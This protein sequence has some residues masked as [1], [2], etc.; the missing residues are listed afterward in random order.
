MES[1]EV[2]RPLRLW[3]RVNASMVMCSKTW[4]LHRGSSFAPL[5]GCTPQFGSLDTVVQQIKVK[6]KHL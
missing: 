5:R 3:L 6:P 2:V 4:R 1:Q